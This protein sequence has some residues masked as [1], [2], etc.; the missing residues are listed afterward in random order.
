MGPA[1]V[2][3]VARESILRIEFVQLDHDSIS[4]DLGDDRC[5]ADRDTEGVALDDGFRRARQIRDRAAIDKDEIKSGAQFLERR[6]HSSIGRTQYVDSIDYFR[7]DDSH[8][9]CGIGSDSLEHCLASLGG[10]RLGIADSICIETIGKDYSRRD[11]WSGE[12]TTSG[13]IKP[14]YVNEA[15]GPYLP[16]IRPRIKIVQFQSQ[17]ETLA[18]GI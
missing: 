4:R 2:T 10:H 15:F 6:S 7:L 16:L 17:S 12:R 11:Y 14:S 9:E 5:R 18:I 13:F 1:A 3:F 8:T